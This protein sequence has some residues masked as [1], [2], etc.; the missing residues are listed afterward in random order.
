[1]GNKKTS[2]KQFI[3][4]YNNVEW[5]NLF[6]NNTNCQKLQNDMLN[7][8][9]NIIV[10]EQKTHNDCGDT[11]KTELFKYIEYAIHEGN[12]P[13]KL[14]TIRKAIDNRKFKQQTFDKN[15]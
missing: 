5:L 3:D 15:L 4:A 2:S 14:N 10:E 12:A 6:G 8:I 9:Y 7:I 1:M 13:K 11:T